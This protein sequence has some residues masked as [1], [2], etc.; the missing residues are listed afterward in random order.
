MVTPHRKV[1]CIDVEQMIADTMVKIFSAIGCEARAAYT[2]E[3]ALEIISE[4]P[5][6]LAIIEVVLP[7]MNGIDLAVLLNARFPVCRLLLV[8]GEYVTG[9]L[10][11]EAK[12]KGHSFE[13]LA[14]PIHP[15]V[16]LEAAN[17]LWHSSAG[18]LGIPRFRDVLE[19]LQL[20]RVTFVLTLE[21]S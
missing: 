5:P 17:A 12:A 15:L 6:D 2:A 1:L 13:V 8:S 21:S 14:K 20:H 16:L 18:L 19:P 7:G 10:L 4:W 11:A 3:Q 9:D